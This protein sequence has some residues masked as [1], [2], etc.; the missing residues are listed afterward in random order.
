MQGKAGK[1]SPYFVENCV[2]L[3]RT[4]PPPA[5]PKAAVRK[6]AAKDETA[7]HAKHTNESKQNDFAHFAVEKSVSSRVNPRFI[8]LSAFRVTRHL[9][10]VTVN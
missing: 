3:A 10:H 6:L 8:F 4:H 7:N 9:A 2:D 5:S 1:R